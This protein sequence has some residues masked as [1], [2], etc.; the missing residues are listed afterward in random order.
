MTDSELAII[1]HQEITDPSRPDEMDVL[2][3]VSTVT[4]ALSEL[5]YR[6]DVQPFPLDFSGLARTLRQKNPAFVFNLVESVAGKGSLQ[7]IAATLLESFGIPFTGNSSEAIYLTTNKQLAKK[8]LIHNDLPT[9]DWISEDN[10][11]PIHPGIKYIVKPIGED[12]SNHIFNDSVMEFSSRREV[13][14]VLAEKRASGGFPFFAEQYI[15]GRDMSLSLIGSFEDAEPLP[16]TEATFS[17]FEENNLYKI[18]NYNAKW[19]PDS[20]EADHVDRTFDFG[21][22]DQSLVARLREIAMR[23]WKVFGLKGYARIDFRVDAE[24]NPYVLEIN[25]NPCIMPTGG[26][27]SACTRVGY[28]IPRL[29]KKLIDCM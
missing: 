29:I 24:R 21:P 17:N 22:G 18:L 20:F 4:D 5:G 8:I 26:F 14:K 11:G 19:V 12:A 2:D 28:D 1:L 27:V 10:E 6:I 13:L 15:D 23:C 16:P 9:P 7:F 25:T 3:Q